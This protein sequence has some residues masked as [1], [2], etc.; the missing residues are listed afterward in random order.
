MT[1]RIRALGAL[2]AVFS[3]FAMAATV[4][5]QDRPYSEGNVT[6]V[7]AI[8]TLPGM[9]E[10]YMR[11]LATTYKANME[12]AKKQGIILGYSIQETSP[13][14][15]DDPNLYLMVTYKNM[16]ALDGLDERM[17]SIQQ[18]SFG[19]QAARDAAAIDREKMR[20]QLGSRIIRE[21]VLK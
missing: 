11:F 10:T 17:E 5:A 9:R 6:V 7:N 19:D 15:P 21:V 2:A 16:A 3:F 1:I 8:R 20:R 4:Q 13:R 12:E 18:K 14:S